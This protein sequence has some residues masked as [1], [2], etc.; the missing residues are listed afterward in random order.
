MMRYPLLLVAGTLALTL[1]LSSHASFQEPAKPSDKPLYQP[2]GNEAT[3]SGTITV[4]GEVPPAKKIDTSADPLCSQV[5]K[6][7]ILESLLT[8]N[9]K[10]QQKIDLLHKKKDKQKKQI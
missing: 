7:P 1:A 6:H 8:N 5:N 3:V 4:N 2:T 10:T 9:Q